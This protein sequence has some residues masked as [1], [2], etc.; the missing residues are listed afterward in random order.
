[1]TI[2]GADHLLEVQTLLVLKSCETKLQPLR[3]LRSTFLNIVSSSSSNAD[4][5]DV[6]A[7]PTFGLLGAFSTSL[8]AGNLPSEAQPIT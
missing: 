6:D 7:V 4:L 1:M 8:S 5:F 2:Q 3:M